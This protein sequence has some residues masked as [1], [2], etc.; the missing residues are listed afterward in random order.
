MPVWPCNAMNTNA[1]ASF[2]LPV[3][4]ALIIVLVTLGLFFRL[5]NLETK[6]YWMD[7]IFTSFQIAGGTFKELVDKELDEKLFAGREISVQHIQQYQ[8]IRSEKGLLDV[9]GTLA[10]EDPVHPPLYFVLAR[11]WAELFGESAGAIRALSAFF[12]LLAIP[13]LYWLCRELFDS[14]HIAWMAVVIM[15]VSP[16]H[17]LYAQEARPY[18]LWIL[19]T[20]VSSAAFL[21]A[22]RLKTLRG[23]EVYAVT[24]V[25]GIYSHLLF[26]LVI[27][28]H[29]IYLV[30]VKKLTFEKSLPCL[31]AGIAFLPWVL[32]VLFGVSRIKSSTRW[33]RT[34]DVSPLFRLKRWTVVF[35]SGFIDPSGTYVTTANYLDS[36]WVD[37]IRL[38]VLLLI[39]YSL[40]FVYHKASNQV[41]P[42][43]LALTG[44][45]A[46][47]LVL[48]DL[49]LGWQISAHPRFLTPYYL[50]VLLSVAYFLVAKMTSPDACRR[51]IWQIITIT[52]IAGEV[53]S[54][55][56]SAFAETWW[57]K[58]RSNPQVA[59]LI[60]QA[61]RPLLIGASDWPSFA[62][63]LTLSNVLD[64]KV[65]IRLLTDSGGLEIPDGF[66]DIFLI[67]PSEPLRQRLEQG[68]Y[69][70]ESTQVSELR[71][72]TTKP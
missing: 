30:T 6:I 29:T 1:K 64:P 49:T 20:I 59:R 35:S 48:S 3:L 61:T 56:I 33:V 44:S 34:A 50:G 65:R 26:G 47:P 14:P 53:V 12:G 11:L 69:Q 66:S 8:P 41:W 2:S 52:I 45:A 72:L 51:R 21:R 23:W 32:T 46:I 70:I 71:H 55:A 42:F 39:G 63:I 19:M 27:L 54:C 38:P 9:V 57:N 16:F 28:G 68:G 7:E 15:V 22:M 25:V 10:A 31:F 37:L 18:S 58:G 67:S 5:G 4:Q 60:N 62:N 40:F 13:S 17:V 43:V 24:L 36:S